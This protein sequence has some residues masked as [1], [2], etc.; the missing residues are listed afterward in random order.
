VSPKNRDGG[1]AF[2]ILRKDVLKAIRLGSASDL[3]EF[4]TILHPKHFIE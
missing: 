2:E 3:A 4:R 1:F